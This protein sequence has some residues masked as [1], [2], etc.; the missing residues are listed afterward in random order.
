[1]KKNLLFSIIFAGAFFTGA[2]ILS[3][4]NHSQRS[5]TSRISLRLV[6]DDVFNSDL[7]PGAAE[8]ER[9]LRDAISW[10]DIGRINMLME[11]PVLRK[12]VV[13][14]T[15][16]INSV[17]CNSLLAEEKKLEVI[18]LFV[19][20]YDVP[21]DIQEKEATESNGLSN[22]ASLD[23]KTPLYYAVLLGLPSI[24]GYLLINGA[25]LS[26]GIRKVASRKPVISRIIRDHD[27]KL[28]GVHNKFQISEYEQAV[29]GVRDVMKKMLDDHR[30]KERR[31]R[32]KIPDQREE[33]RSSRSSSQ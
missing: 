9:S 32:I 7:T 2:S 29:K 24:V 33:H 22:G 4:W 21:F 8:K 6:D 28:S 15:V 16:W 30:K 27:A 3:M 23:I 14:D 11:D 18:K 13:R 26:P 17:I 31:L 20:T 25:R 5:R 10:A 12:E 1:V 19:E